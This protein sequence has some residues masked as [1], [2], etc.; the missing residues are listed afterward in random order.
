MSLFPDRFWLS[1]LSPVSSMS[2]RER[3]SGSWIRYGATMPGTQPVNARKQENKI[4][5]KGRV[6][7]RL[8]SQPSKA[9]SGTHSPL[10]LY[11]QSGFLC[12][13]VHTSQIDSLGHKQMAKFRWPP[14]E[15]HLLTVAV[16]LT[17]LSWYIAYE[18]MVLLVRPLSI[19]F[20]YFS[21]L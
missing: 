10:Q 9:I 2:W 3:S 7:H 13:A 16:S 19:Q 5:R 18:W 1:N 8:S 14:E 12:P 17:W 11:V 20:F 21:D 15:G 4:L 6:A